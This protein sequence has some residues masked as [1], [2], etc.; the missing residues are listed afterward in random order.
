MNDARWPELPAEWADTYATLHMWTQIVGKIALA[1]SPPLNH[2]WGVALQVTPRGLSTRPLPHGERVFMLEFDFVDHQLVIAAAD[3]ARRTLPLRPQSVADF[4]R[5]VMATLNE[6]K[7]PVHIWT[8][9]VEVPNPIPFEK[10][11]VHATYEPE[12][13]NRVWRIFVQSERVLSSA[14]CQFV[15]KCS[16]AHFFWGGFDLALTRFSG[17]PAPDREGPE[18]MREAYSHEVISHGF[19][20][21]GGPL[22]E[23]AFYAYAAPVPAGLEAMPVDPPAY[24]HRELGEYILPYNAMRTSADPDQTLRTFIDRTY[25]QAANL[26]HWNRAALEQAPRPQHTVHH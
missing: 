2:S 19:W 16:P 8:T 17:R 1:Q 12:Y 11:T 4:Y 3:G 5:D 23:P 24:Y 14:R 10:D 20:P 21:G 7:L 26:A 18:F 13:A 15:G 22:Q 6:M 9:P 25:E